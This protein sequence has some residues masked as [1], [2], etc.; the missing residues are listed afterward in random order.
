MSK[1]CTVFLLFTQK[2]VLLFTFY[3]PF[4]KSE[5]SSETSYNKQIF[6]KK[7]S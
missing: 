3:P 5:L 2:R 6:P 1:T 4:T 7:K